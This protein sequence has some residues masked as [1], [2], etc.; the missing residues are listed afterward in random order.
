MMTYGYFIFGYIMNHDT[1]CSRVTD[2]GLHIGSLRWE[3]STIEHILSS[4][5]LPS[6]IF[7]VTPTQISIPFHAVVCKIIERFSL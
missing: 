3:Q 1:L 2:I 4:G 5:E 6:L 7:S